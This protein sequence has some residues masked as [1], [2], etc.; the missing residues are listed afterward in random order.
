[1]DI[2]QTLT[3]RPQP[4]SQADEKGPSKTSSDFDTFLKL[5]TA[6]IRN[7]DPLEPADATAYTAQLATFSNVEQAVQTNTLLSEMIG[8]L[9]SQQATSAAG[10][11]G[12]EVRHSGAVGHT[13]GQTALYT[14]VNGVADR[15][16]LVVTDMRGR[17]VARHPVDPKAEVLGWPAD[18]RGGSVPD[19]SYDIRIESWAGDRALDPTPVAHYA[20]VDEAVM[21]KAGTELLLRGGVR[22]PIGALESI[23]GPSI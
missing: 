14:A 8:K 11:I 19:G 17:E 9:D 13:G 6:Q 3:P 23:R 10:Y 7:Q 2:Q 5:L 4:A 22:L 20:R 21:G 12:M 1:M 16:E 15:A 18:G